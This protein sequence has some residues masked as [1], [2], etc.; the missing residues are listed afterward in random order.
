MSLVVRT[1]FVV[2]FPDSGWKLEVQCE[3]ATTEFA[4]YWNNK[5]IPTHVARVL[6]SKL[7][8][9]LTTIKDH[10]ED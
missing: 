6:T 9:M 4:L 10:E 8:E 2:R 5:E 7:V 1:Y 3:G